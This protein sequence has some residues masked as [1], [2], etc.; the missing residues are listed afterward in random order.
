M[1]HRAPEVSARRVTDIVVAIGAVANAVVDLLP[2]KWAA[3]VHKS[4]KAV[5]SLA[6]GV[7]SFT[8]MPE[9]FPPSIAPWAVLASIVATAIVTYWTPNASSG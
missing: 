5:V 9:L 4:R 6:G 1:T 7:V 8:A 2:A 3:W